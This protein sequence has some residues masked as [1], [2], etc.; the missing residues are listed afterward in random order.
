M[1]IC[2][3]DLHVA[4]LALQARRPELAPAPPPACASPSGPAFCAPP[5]RARTV[6]DE[7]AL[8]HASDAPPRPSPLPRPDLPQA[9]PPPPTPL[10]VINFFIGLLKA[11]SAAS[12][13]LPKSHFFSTMFY[14]RL[15][16]VGRAAPFHG[17][18]HPVRG[19]RPMRPPG[20]SKGPRPL[21]RNPPTSRAWPSPLTVASIERRPPNA[22]RDYL[23]RQAARASTIMMPSSASPSRWR[24]V[25][26]VGPRARSHRHQSDRAIPALTRIAPAPASRS[27]CFAQCLAQLLITPPGGRLLP[28]P[29]LLPHPLP[30]Q[31][32]DARPRQLL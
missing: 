25:W 30:R 8:A 26:R 12:P 1:L 6:D 20:V 4:H 27:A 19:Y 5:A 2:D 32:L 18:V 16:G 31:P 10:Q 21:L 22:R 9:P 29:P 23:N 11:R 3:S 28:R 24:R 17:A 13:Q 15:S 14:T 7:V